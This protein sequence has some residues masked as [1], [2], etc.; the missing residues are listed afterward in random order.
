M[1]AKLLQAKPIRSRKKFA[2][3]K[4]GCAS[5]IRG[6]FKF[7]RSIETGGVIL[8]R[9]LEKY[10]LKLVQTSLLWNVFE[11]K[12]LC[13]AEGKVSIKFGYFLNVF[14]L[15]LLSYCC[16]LKHVSKVFILLR[17]KFTNHKDKTNVTEKHNAICYLS[18]LSCFIFWVFLPNFLAVMFRN[19]TLT[20]INLTHI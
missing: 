19:T 16:F 7:F 5:R 8:T 15:F 20:L 4:Q 13:D 3:N 10:T 12:S 1:T 9:S 18:A 14:E 17:S 6:K 2:S 11:I